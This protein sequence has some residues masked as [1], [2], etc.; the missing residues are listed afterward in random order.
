MYILFNNSNRQRK[1]FCKVHI[2]KHNYIF[3]AVLTVQILYS[4]TGS[5]QR[6][7]R[8]FI[9]NAFAKLLCCIYRFIYSWVPVFIL[10]FIYLTPFRQGNLTWFSFKNLAVKSPSGEANTADFDHIWTCASSPPHEYFRLSFYEGKKE[11]KGKS[12]NPEQNVW[13][14]TGSEG[15]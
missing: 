6:V 4:Y 5:D 3:L 10:S 11:N 7:M 14:L 13:S 8:R 1:L 9:F 2:N 15:F 12:I